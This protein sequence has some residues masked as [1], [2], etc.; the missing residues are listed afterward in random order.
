MCA[1]SGIAEVVTYDLQMLLDL[2]CG[3]REYLRVCGNVVVHAVEPYELIQGKR[4]GKYAG[5]TC[6]LFNDGEPIAFT[7]FYNVG[8]PQP[9]YIRNTQA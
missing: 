3:E 7:V 6:F 5:F 8:E 9:D 1:D 4:N 2:P